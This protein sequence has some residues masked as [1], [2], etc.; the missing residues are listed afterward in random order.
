MKKLAAYAAIFAVPTMIAG[1]YGMN[2]A[3]IPGAGWRLGF[4]ASVGVMAVLCALLYRYFRRAG[5]L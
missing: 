2:F 5:W 1:V 4:L 3:F